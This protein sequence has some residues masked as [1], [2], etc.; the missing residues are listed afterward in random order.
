MFF[1]DVWFFRVGC[2]NKNCNKE[3]MMESA[4]LYVIRAESEIQKNIENTG[5]PPTRE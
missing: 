4:N 2:G 3:N 1:K 5:F